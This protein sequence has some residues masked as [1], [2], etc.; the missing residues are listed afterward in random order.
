MAI[1]FNLINQGLLTPGTYVEF[2]TTRAQQGPSLRPYK[3]LMVGPSLAAGTMPSRSLKQI[4][5]AS[6][7]REFYGPGSILAGMARTYLTENKINEL[8]CYNVPDAADSVKAT[9]TIVFSGKATGPGLIE[10]TFNGVQVSYGVETEATAAQVAKGFADAINALPD[11]EITATVS[12][13]TVTIT[14]KN[15]GEAANGS[16]MERTESLYPPG[17]TSVFVGLGSGNRGGTNGSKNP[18]G[19]DVIGAIGEERFDLICNP[20]IDTGNMMKWITELDDRWGPLRQNDGH[21]VTGTEGLLS[22]VTAYADTLNSE[23]VTVIDCI[24][25]DGANKWM[26]NLTAVLARELQ[27]DPARPLQSVPLRALTPPPASAERSQGERNTLLSKGVTTVRTGP[28]AV[29][30]ERVRTTK[31]LNAFGEADISLADLNTKATLSYIRYD[32][33]TRFVAKFS[34]H[35]LAD[36]GTRFGPGQAVLTP[37]TAKAEIVSMFAEWE[38]LGLVEGEQQFENDLIV[39]R[40][41]TDPNRLDIQMPPD[42]INQLRVGAAQV[43][44]LL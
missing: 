44:F 6:Q 13:A 8:W 25:I 14:A 33:R 29:T 19:F 26:A 35:K 36:D 28:S 5:S 37:I 1:S 42:L 22:Q 20:F 32:F 41:A 17:I 10:Y 38:E 23:H 39:E 43:Q 27:S 16:R 40:N 7:A 4:T 21:M 18:A 12:T 3:V 11:L 15:A 2:D 24:G 9:G 34:R 31:K 30:L